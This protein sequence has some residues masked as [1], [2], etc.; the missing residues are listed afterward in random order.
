MDE[1]PESISYLR[2][3]ENPAVYG[4]SESD[5]PSTPLVQQQDGC[6]TNIG[7]VVWRP[8]RRFHRHL[9]AQ[10]R[11][12]ETQHVRDTHLEPLWCLDSR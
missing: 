12:S 8:P 6:L 4:G 9:N 5:N 1:E 10:Y 2:R 7:I 3:G 11:D